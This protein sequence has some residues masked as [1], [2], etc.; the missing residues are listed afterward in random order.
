MRPTSPIFQTIFFDFANKIPAIFQT[1]V[2]NFEDPYDEISSWGSNDRWVR[3]IAFILYVLYICVVYETDLRGKY[4]YDDN[5]LTG[6]VYY[7]RNIIDGI[8]ATIASTLFETFDDDKDAWWVMDNIPDI[9]GMGTSSSTTH[10]T[11]IQIR[12]ERFLPIFHQ[13]LLVLQES[14]EYQN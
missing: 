14:R 7:V 3:Q 4:E 13:I 2:A 10:D 5:S 11:Q 1:A 8:H 9:G 6:L 12:S